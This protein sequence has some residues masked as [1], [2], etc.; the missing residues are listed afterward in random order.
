MV[1]LNG[2]PYVEMS[3]S[4][5]GMVAQTIILSCINTISINTILYSVQNVDLNGTIFTNHWVITLICTDL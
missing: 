3:V 4:T 1:F 2:F 5:E